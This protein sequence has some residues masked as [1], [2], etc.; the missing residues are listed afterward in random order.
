[1]KITV[2]IPAYN[3]AENIGSLLEAL[4]AQKLTNEASLCQL[5]VISDGST[6]A[7][8]AI[9]SGWMKQDSRVEL[10]QLHKR[11]GKPTAINEIFRLTR[12]DVIVLLDADT[13]PIGDRFLLEITKRLEN[14]TEVGIIAAIGIPLPPES[15]VGR[16]AVFSSNMRR[17][18]FWIRP[19][20]AF[21]VALALSAK[22]VK[23]LRLPPGIIGDDAYLYFKSKCQGLKTIVSR[24]AR[25]L[26]REPQTFRDFIIQR[27]KY[28]KNVAQLRQR[29]GTSVREHIRIPRKLWY[30]F[31]QE[32]FSDPLGG[33]VWLLLRAF[34]KLKRTMDTK[35]LMREV[36]VSTKNTLRTTA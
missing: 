14:G 18:L 4:F 9:V 3:E 19:Y 23:N 8:P 32:M 31:L 10:Y 13:L 36:A 29:F 21:N 27:E 33:I 5:L 1:V 2:G 6:D 7:T 25:I 11:F 26:Y 35:Q 30:V 12:G 28:E 24:N 34:L 15:L 17:R 16:A 20:F 22:A